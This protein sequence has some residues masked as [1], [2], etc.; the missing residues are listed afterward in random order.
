[1]S[2]GIT[3]SEPIESTFPFLAGEVSETHLSPAAALEA[4]VIHLFDHLRKP[5]LRY[6]LGTGLRIQD[7]E[8]IAQEVFL[9]LFQHLKSG[10]S[11]EFLNAWVFRVA[12][13]LGLK[14]MNSVKRHVDS[15]ENLIDRTPNPEDRAASGQ[16]QQRLLAVIKALPEV[17][18]RCLYLRSEGLRYREI[19]EILEISLGAVSGSLTRSLARI[20]RAGATHAGTTP[21]GTTAWGPLR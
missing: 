14:R 9:A 7:A 5:L 17:D 18:R 6:L 1:M 16:R 8:E 19:A 15:D 20:A 12:H 11:R 10:K 2:K 13:N 4:D 3:M 21:A